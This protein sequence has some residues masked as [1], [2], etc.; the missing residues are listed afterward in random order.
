M[1]G[2][3]YGEEI[4]MVGRTMWT[5][6]TSVTDRQTDRITITKTV[7]RR[8]SNGKNCLVGSVA[9]CAAETWA[10]VMKTDRSKLEAFEMWI[11]GRMEIIS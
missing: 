10:V 2:L 5:Q 6:S 3:P 11:W 8:A 9:L 7:Q 4:M 1:M